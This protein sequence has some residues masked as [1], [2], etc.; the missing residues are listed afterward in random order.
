MLR[1]GG[2]IP[3]YDFRCRVC[4]FQTE[5]QLKIADRD[6]PTLCPRCFHHALE[7]QLA[8]PLFRFA[9]QTASGGGPDKFTADML[10]VPLKDLPPG[11][12]TPEKRK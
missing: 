11:L 7:R 8:A 12:R 3:L 2:N 1:D 4:D 9:G 10:R 6:L 5:C